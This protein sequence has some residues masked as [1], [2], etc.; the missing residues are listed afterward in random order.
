MRVLCLFG[1]IGRLAAGD[2]IDSVGGVRFGP[3]VVRSHSL[4]SLCGSI[5]DL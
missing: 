1:S 2:K 5:V 3:G 4:V